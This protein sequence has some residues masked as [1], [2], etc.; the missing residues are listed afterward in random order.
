MGMEEVCSS[1]SLSSFS[2]HRQIVAEEH[3]SS[4]EEAG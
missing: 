3:R 1:S 4:G 2:S